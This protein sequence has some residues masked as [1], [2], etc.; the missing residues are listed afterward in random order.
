MAKTQGPGLAGNERRHCDLIAATADWLWES[1]A[2]GCVNFVSPDFEASTGLLPQSLLGKCLTDLASTGAAPAVQRLA[3]GAEKPF[4]DL[5]AKL[6]RPDGVGTWIEIAGTPMLEAGG[7][8]GYCGIGKTVTARVETDLAVQRYRRLFEVASDWFCEADADGRLT[9]VSPNSEAVLDLPPSAYYGKRL[10]D[11]DGV[12]I[13]PEAGRASLAAIKA[14]QPYRD[15]IYS[16]KLPNGKIVWINSSGMPFYGEDGTFLGYH[17]IARNVTAQV[18]AERVLRENEQEYRGM[19]E[20]A[21]DYY[22][23]NDTQNR[24]TH[25]SPGFEKFLGVSVTEMIGKRINDIPGVSIDL[26]TLRMGLQA[27]TLR[28]PFRDFVFSRKCADGKLRWFKTS[29]AAKFNVDGTF[30]GYR[31]VGAEITAHVE[32][33]QAARLGQQRLHEAVAHIVQPIVIYDTQDRTVAFNQLFFDLRRAP[34]G[35]YGHIEQ[36][37]SFREIAE[38][39]LRVGF[40]AG[41][42]NEE[43]IT[44]D[45]LLERYQG[46]S[47][48]TYHLGDGR[49]MMVIYRQ[50]PGGGSGRLV[51]RHHCSQARRGRAALARGAAASRAAPRGGGHAGRRRRARDQ[52]RA[53][54]GDRPHQDDGRQTAGGQPRAAQSRHRRER[55]RARAGS[56]EADPRLQP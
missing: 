48:H 16:R 30:A 20:A 24:Y 38:W 28:Q 10:A 7:F 51:D 53:G 56:G 5:V 31:G 12:V 32:A 13:E 37:I 36:G 46:E 52:Q 8:C 54:A 43:A 49:W 50:L 11:T 21:A 25:L 3:I 2:G 29:G 1:D 35:D 42:P 41:G 40:Y 22:W 45:L 27:M 15:F 33:I 39:Q 47:E 9:Y 34:N 55:R 19:L 4:R 23:E 26:A 17:G 44:I 14:R 18:E 6:E